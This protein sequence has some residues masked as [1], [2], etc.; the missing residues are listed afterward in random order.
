MIN[1]MRHD[2]FRITRSRVVAL[3]LAVLCCSVYLPFVTNPFV[4]DDHNLF[5]KPNFIDYAFQFWLAPRWLPYATLAHTHVI[6]GGSI[7]ALR[8]GN[9]FLHVVNVV[10][11]FVLLRELC[12]ASFNADDIK[13][14]ESQA[15]VIACTG[16]TFFAV[17]PVAVYAV[18][19][20]VQRTMLMSTLFMLLMLV[21]Y[22]RWLK[23]GRTALWVWSVVWYFLSVFS[24][25]HSVVAPAVAFLL[26]FVVQ[27]PSVTVVRRIVA[28]FFAYA[29]V[30]L[31]VVSMVKGGLGTAYEPYALD[32]IKNGQDV[33]PQSVYSLSVVT[34]LYLYLKYVFL[35]VFPSVSRMS[36][37]MREALAPSVM[38]IPYVA[39]VIG[40]VC[41]ALAA[42]SMLLRGGRWS[43]AGWI[44]LFPLVM[45]ATELS[46]IRVREPFVLY[47]AYLWFPLFGA[48]I[49]LALLRISARL[50]FALVVPLICVQVGLSWNRLH[51]LSDELLAWEDAAKLLVTG[52]ELG[53]DRI[54]YNRALGLIGKNRHREALTDLDRT[55][56]LN[57]SLAPVYFTRATVNFRLNRYL[58]ALYDTNA[59]LALDSTQSSSYLA[60]STVLKKLGRDEEALVDLRK[61]CDMKNV[62]A[63]YAASLES[64]GI[65]GVR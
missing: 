24:K 57:S 4:L 44:L 63:C 48:L 29:V 58:D 37:D 10:L 31:I 47:R 30:A 25:E 22:L 3:L 45:F 21:T 52:R 15:F 19:Y 38:A 65:A 36:L 39:A 6:F 20:V 7:S 2:V 56:A 23:S 1:R 12:L 35:W 49:P 14:R 43:V 42:F 5:G 13:Q 32:T 28:P 64:K 62:I 34:Q 9:L 50:N 54:Y 55:I 60:R 17:H 18:G 51:S 40:I 27:R 8:L 46:T 53:A 59:S 33:A 11:V 61:S 16:A 26:T 41:Y